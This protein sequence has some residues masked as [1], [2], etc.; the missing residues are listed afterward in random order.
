MTK[1]QQLATT[2]KAL[3]PKL[4]PRDGSLP[5]DER[6][7]IARQSQ[8]EHNRL[9]FGLLVQIGD[10]LVRHAQ[11]ILMQLA[12]QHQQQAAAA[13]VGQTQGEALDQAVDTENAM[14]PVQ[15]TVTSVMPAARP[16]DLPI[17]PA[18]AGGNGTMVSVSAPVAATICAPVASS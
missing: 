7:L 14:P 4:Y 13:P 15:A 3:Y 16:I 9:L 6:L 18:P 1:T 10:A 2:L 8:D 5:L 12:A 11:V 17:Q